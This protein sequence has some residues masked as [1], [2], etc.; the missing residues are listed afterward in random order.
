MT[1]ETY[2]IIPNPHGGWCVKRSGATR[3]VKRFDTK[4]DA[5]E[6]SRDLIMS[7]EVELFVHGKDGTIV[8]RDSYG[9]DSHPP[10]G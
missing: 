9:Q 10:K 1:K 3:A 2:H 7:Q 6:Y 4:E 5:V 8:A